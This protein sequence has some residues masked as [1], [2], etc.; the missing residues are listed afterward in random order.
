MSVTGCNR[1]ATVQQGAAGC[2]THACSLFLIY[3]P[4]PLIC[5]QAR[6]LSLLAP[7][8]PV[9]DPLLP[10]QAYDLVL[11]VRGEWQGSGAA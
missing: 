1:P 6:Q 2:P 7:V 3:T 9:K 11:Q 8:L 4:P 10:S 5:P